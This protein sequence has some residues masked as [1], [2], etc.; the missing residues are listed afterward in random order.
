MPHVQTREHLIHVIEKTIEAYAGPS[1]EHWN[2]KACA[3][4][5][6]DIIADLP[7]LC[8]HGEKPNE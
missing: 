7:N 8:F 5:L 6:A 1:V 4:K 2:A 3:N